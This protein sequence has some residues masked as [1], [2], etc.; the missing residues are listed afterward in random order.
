MRFPAPRRARIALAALV[1]PAALAV[2][3]LADVVRGDDQI[4]EGSVCVGFDCISDE[5]FAG[6]TLRLKENNTRLAFTDTSPP[7]SPRN[8]WEITANASASGGQEYL[9]VRDV[10]GGKDV[11]RVM[12]GAPTDVLRL[13]PGGAVALGAGTARTR[14][15]GSTTQGAVPVDPDAVLTALAA[16]PLTTSVSSAA[17]SAGRRLGP[18]AAEFNAAF[19]LGSGDDLAPADVAGVALAAVAAIAPKVA[20]ATPGGAGPVG[21]TGATGAPGSPGAPG[22]AGPRG[23]AGANAVSTLRTDELRRSIRRLEGLDRVE[24]RRSSGLRTRIARAD[25]RT[26]TR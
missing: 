16:L 2:P 20:A 5:D 11:L 26:R 13:T 23:A 7:G 14:V 12:G 6:D 4:V 19:G 3:A 21:P 24:R 8:A 15:D 17:P 1:V 25:R 22:A 10:T 18:S 9:G